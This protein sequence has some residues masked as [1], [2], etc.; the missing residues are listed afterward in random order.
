MSVCSYMRGMLEFMFQSERNSDWVKYQKSLCNYFYFISGQ[1]RKRL[2][3]GDDDDDDDVEVDD[4][5]GGDVGV[6][7]DG[8]G[9]TD[10]SEI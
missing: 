3:D 7:V 8:G 2:E 6:N 10:K 5:D 4:D 9:R 1:S